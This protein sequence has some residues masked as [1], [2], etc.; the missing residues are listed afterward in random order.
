MGFGAALRYS[1]DETFSLASDG[2]LIA[3]GDSRLMN[4]PGVATPG[5][6]CF[7]ATRP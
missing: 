2:L 5:R 7:Q 6:S 4:R 3:S 1:H